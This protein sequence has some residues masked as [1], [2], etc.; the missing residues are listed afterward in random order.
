M[1]ADVAQAVVRNEQLCCG[2]VGI[3]GLEVAGGE[4]VR[5]Q[6]DEAIRF[7]AVVPGGAAPIHKG[8]AVRA[9]FVDAARP[10]K[11]S[12]RVPRR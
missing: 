2:E 3:R 4:V 9:G 12:A 10:E 11:C 8:S 7:A 1:F 6:D 5:T